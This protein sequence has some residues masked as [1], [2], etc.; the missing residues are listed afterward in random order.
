MPRT[1]L[2]RVLLAAPTALGVALLV[3]ALLRA[4][5]GDPVD[6]MLGE[7]ATAGDRA[8]LRQAL[9]LD[10]PAS[11]QLARFLGGLA[12]GDLGG[13][14]IDGEPVS[15]LILERYPATLELAAA[16]VAIALIVAVPLGIAAAPRPGSSIDRL[17][18][19]FAL[20]ATS[21]PTFAL[22][23]LLI[24]GFSVELGW[25]PVA[26][27]SGAASLVL[28]GATLGIGMAAILARHLC[29]ALRAALDLD[30][31]RAARARGVPPAGLLLRHAL[32]NASTA[33]VTVFGLQVGGLLAGAIVTETIFAW[34]GLGRL[35]VQAIGSRD[36]PVAQGCV[37]AI[38]LT[39]VAVNLATDL[40]QAWLD[41]RLRGAP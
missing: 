9:G 41:P 2:L 21:L 37:L 33:V 32:R 5:P 10:Q 1:L 29:V 14:L 27:R 19:G 40:L 8:A 15:R 26:G 24:L 12:R 31:I 18:L 39:Y 23:P 35:L 13:S 3:F 36:Y 30:C 4:L 20:G 11:L 16:A 25:L 28:P 38:A 34:P 17:L 7:T 22:G 6:A